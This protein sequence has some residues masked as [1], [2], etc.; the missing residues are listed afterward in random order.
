ME[1]HEPLLNSNVNSNKHVY[2]GA[3][4]GNVLHKKK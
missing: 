2:Y 1:I 4:N 3:S